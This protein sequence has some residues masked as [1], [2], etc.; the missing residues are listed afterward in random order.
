MPRVAAPVFGV[1]GQYGT[2]STGFSDQVQPGDATSIQSSKRLAFRAAMAPLPENRTPYWR[3]MVLDMFE[4]R[5]WIAA[6][7]ESGR[8]AFIPDRDAPRVEQEIFLEP[9]NRGVLFALDQPVSVSGVEAL[10]R[11]DGMYLYQSRSVGRRLQYEAVSRLSS[12]MRPV[13]PNFDKSRT[14]LL[15]PGFIPRLRPI[16]SDMTRGMSDR[17]KAEAIMGYLA[18]PAFEYSLSGLPSDPRNAVEQFIFTSRRG[19]CEYFAFA[20]GV[21]LR[22]AGV[23]S[24]LVSG[25]MGGVYNDVGGYYIVQEDKAHVWVE[26]WD[27]EAGAWVRYDPTPAGGAGAA[28]GLSSLEFYL[29]MLDYQWSKLVVNY[30]WEVQADLLQDL[31]EILRNPRASLTPTGDG[32]RR[33]GSALSGIVTTGAVIALCA[34]LFCLLRGFRNRQPEIMLLRRFLSVMKRC[35]YVRHESEGL[36]EFLARVGDEKLRILALPFVRRFEEFYYRDGAASAALRGALQDRLRK[37][38]RYTKIEYK[39]GR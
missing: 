17:E 27:E 4:G 12:R 19:N 16:V 1:R 33:M 31:R 38:T 13:D 2:V 35:G 15:P 24:R 10:D 18:P 22:M 3:G 20:M 32:L 21:M 39:K 30:N 28:D 6:R 26:A 8:Q 5:M 11:G 9:G 37:I 34:G 23:P 25:Y 14:L 29:D 36:E 7:G